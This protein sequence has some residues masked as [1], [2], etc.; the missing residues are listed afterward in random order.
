M[1]SGTISGSARKSIFSLPCD[2]ELTSLRLSVSESEAF[3]VWM[4]ILASELK[5]NISGNDIE[6][7]NTST[8]VVKDVLY[9]S[10]KAVYH[11][12]NYYPGRTR[13]GSKNKIDEINFIIKKFACN[14]NF[15]F[16]I[17]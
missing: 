4:I 6:V 15:D 5:P 7:D 12:N 13:F 17:G 3:P 10:G 14:M 11:L 16:L 1:I 8:D 9:F 2:V